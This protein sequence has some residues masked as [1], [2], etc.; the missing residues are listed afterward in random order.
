LPDFPLL[1]GLSCRHFAFSQAVMA[2]C[3]VFQHMPSTQP[4]EPTELSDDLPLALGDVLESMEDRPASNLLEDSNEGYVCDSAFESVAA[5]TKVLL[6]DEPPAASLDAGGA[7][8][9]ASVGP[10][11]SAK[12]TGAKVPG[13]KKSSAK[14]SGAKVVEAKVVDSRAVV[15]EA[16]DAEAVGAKLGA[17]ASDLS[18]DPSAGRLT[19]REKTIVMECWKEVQAKSNKAADRQA[20]GNASDGAHGKFEQ[21]ARE[22]ESGVAK[23]KGGRFG[24]LFSQKG[25]HGETHDE[26]QSE[27]DVGHKSAFKIP[28]NFEEMGQMNAKMIGADETWIAMVISSFDHLVVAVVNE[29]D[30]RL[31]CEVTLLAIRGHKGARKPSLRDF[32]V[33]MMTSMRALVPQRWDSEHERAW[34]HVWAIIEE[35]ATA[36]MALPA[37]YE[38]SVETFVTGLAPET[39]HEIG[40]EVFNKMFK[41]Y[42]KSENFFKQSNSRL[43]FIVAKAIDI[44]AQLFTEPDAC[45]NEVL[46]LGLRHIMY[47]VPTDFFGPFATFIADE[48]EA[49]CDSPL[50]SEGFRWSLDLVSYTMMR[51]VEEGSSPLL[52]AIAENDAKK[53][54]KALGGAG[55][56]DRAK[57][58][59]NSDKAAEIARS[60]K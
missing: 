9:V 46:A 24:G 53:V 56:V 54:K 30:A 28:Q 7:M 39:K 40:L 51:A 34:M 59:L 48:I 6:Y 15:A 60:K 45:V 44:A 12:A 10:L 14:S 19:E 43:C 2:P 33:C 55:R 11:A 58:A 29:D 8:V 26:S 57:M 21:E 52:I 49:R 38:K 31:L 32:Q 5:K 27:K 50:A 18:S 22:A 1:R 35:P 42:P 41:Q 36:V 23:Q 37:K 16:T 4:V 3:A 20:G 25:Q 13:K 47:K 17:K